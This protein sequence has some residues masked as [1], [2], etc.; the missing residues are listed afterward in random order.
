M[1]ISTIAIMNGSIIRHLRSY[2]TLSDWSNSHYPCHVRALEAIDIIPGEGIQ[3][4]NEDEEL[5]VS[6]F[7]VI[8]IAICVLFVFGVG[9]M[10]YCAFQKQSDY[11]PQQANQT[12][13]RGTRRPVV[14]NN[15]ANDPTEN[16]A[17]PD[18]RRKEKIAAS[19]HYGTIC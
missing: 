12:R 14:R 10:G 13:R 18:P 15:I 7:T 11:D 5:A 2:R 8:I 6:T 9:L 4:Q 1:N 16:T 19:L 17:P 3:Q